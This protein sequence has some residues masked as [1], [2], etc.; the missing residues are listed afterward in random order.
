MSAISK[1]E[2]HSHKGQQKYIYENMVFGKKINISS[3]SSIGMIG[4]ENDWRRDS[5]ASRN[6]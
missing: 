4:T 3:S 2:G 5:L 6:S 1:Q